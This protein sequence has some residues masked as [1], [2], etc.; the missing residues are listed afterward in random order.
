MCMY[1]YIYIYIYI[2]T[3]RERERDVREAADAFWDCHLNVE[4]KNTSRYER[5]ESWER[6]TSR[7]VAFGR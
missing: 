5:Q 4:N 1:V 2:Y 7:C 3:Y 6:Y